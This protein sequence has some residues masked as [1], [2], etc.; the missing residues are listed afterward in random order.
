MTAAP[1][2]PAEVDAEPVCCPFLREGERSVAIC[3]AGARPWLVAPQHRLAVCRHER[4]QLCSRYPFAEQTR[5][6]IRRLSRTRAARLGLVA[7]IVAVCLATAALPFVGNP[8][9]AEPEMPVGSAT[10]LP[11]AS[12]PSQ[13]APAARHAGAFSGWHARLVWPAAAPLVKR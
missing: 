11:S 13:S 8:L 10:P 2:A 12:P 4:Y 6:Q 3:C 9:A 1:L 7:M 5:A